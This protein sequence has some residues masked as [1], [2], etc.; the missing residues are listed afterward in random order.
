M[1]NGV[2][3]HIKGVNRHEH[4]PDFGRAVPVAQMIEDIKIFKQNNINTVRT[5]H[6]PNHP[7]WYDL[8]DCYGL[9]VIDEANIESHGMGYD[10]DKTLGNNPLWE[11]AH[12]DRIVSMVERDKNH[13]CILFWSMGNEAG[14]GCNFE[15]AANAIRARDLSRPIHYERDNRVTDVYSQMYSRIEELEKYVEENDGR[16]LLPLRICTRHGKQCR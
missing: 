11:K 14:G 4:H 13:P 3:I 7:A 6:Y 9:Y 10:S 15:V 8:C 12:L 2:P 16:P 5:S 1:V